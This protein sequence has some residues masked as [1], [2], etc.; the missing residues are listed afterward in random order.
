[1]KRSFF[2]VHFPKH[3][4]R[5]TPDND[6]SYQTLLVKLKIQIKLIHNGPDRDSKTHYKNMDGENQQITMQKEKLRVI[7]QK[8]IPFKHEDSRSNKRK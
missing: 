6:N 3:S 5:S 8:P 1:M 2:Q 4:R 7:N